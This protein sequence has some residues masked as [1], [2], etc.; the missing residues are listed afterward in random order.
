M[1]VKFSGFQKSFFFSF[2]LHDYKG[3][4]VGGMDG[5]EVE[6]QAAEG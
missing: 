3:L 1:S 4:G 2:M 6:E 5:G